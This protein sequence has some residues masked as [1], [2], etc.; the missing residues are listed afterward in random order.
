MESLNQ[1]KAAQYRE[2]VEELD[3]EISSYTMLHP[4]QPLFMNLY[5]ADQIRKTVEKQEPDLTVSEILSAIQMSINDYENRMGKGVEYS[6][7]MQLAIKL[8]YFM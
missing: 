5:I 6:L 3:T 2:L 1:K 4:T 8:S 7:N